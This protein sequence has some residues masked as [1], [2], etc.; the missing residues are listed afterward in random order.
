M[1]EGFC[2]RNFLIARILSRA[3]DVFLLSLGSQLREPSMKGTVVRYKTTPEMAQENECLIQAVFQE[4]RAKSPEGLRYLVLRLHDGT[5][6]HVSTV[7]MQDGAANPLPG[8]EAFRRFQG[9]IKQRCIEPPK[10]SDA[11]VVGNYRML[12]E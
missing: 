4:L 12:G 8:L 5:F 11:I 2:G 1:A 9:G 3:R 6:I 10:V 7:E